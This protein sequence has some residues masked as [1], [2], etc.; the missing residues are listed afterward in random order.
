MYD[1]IAYDDPGLDRV[2]DPLH[3]HGLSLQ[4]NEHT[5]QHARRG[6]YDS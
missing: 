2:S 3:E 4:N 5:R 6:G 1:G